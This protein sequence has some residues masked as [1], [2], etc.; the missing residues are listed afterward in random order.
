MDKSLAKSD[1]NSNIY[2]SNKEN[3]IDN[4]LVIYLEEKQVNKRVSILFI[5][6]LYFSFIF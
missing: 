3:I 6:F 4:K 5:F 1:D 2:I